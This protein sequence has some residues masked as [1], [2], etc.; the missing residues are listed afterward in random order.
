MLIQLLQAGLSM[1]GLLPGAGLMHTGV[2]DGGM[3]ARAEA[4]AA[5]TQR[6]TGVAHQ[7]TLS[8]TRSHPCR[9]S[10]SKRGLQ[11]KHRL[12]GFYLIW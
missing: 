10:T 4:C 2:A 1:C 8:S 5:R 7:Q 11:E 12:Q 9:L 6:C 3:K